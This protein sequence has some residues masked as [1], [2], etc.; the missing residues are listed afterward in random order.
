MS[1]ESE[2][3]ATLE[4]VTTATLTTLLLK[5][6]LRNVWM[7]GTRPMSSSAVRFRPNSCTSSAPNVEMPTSLTH[8]GSEVTSWISAI[9]AGQS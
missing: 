7:R 1:R 6:G 9:F 2:I 3:V 5:K 8:T 4:H